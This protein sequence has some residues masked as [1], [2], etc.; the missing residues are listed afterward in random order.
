MHVFLL[1]GLICIVCFLCFVSFKSVFMLMFCDWKYLRCFCVV[2][3][4]IQYIWRVACALGRTKARLS[5]QWV[6]DPA[7]AAYYTQP[8]THFAGLQQCSAGHRR[9]IRRH[10]SATQPPMLHHWLHWV[11]HD[12]WCL[13]EA[14]NLFSSSSNLQLIV[15]SRCPK[16]EKAP[17]KWYRTDSFVANMAHRLF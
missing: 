6:Q 1:C 14:F 12:Q 2:S 7:E 11:E 8:N 9:S 15:C 16:V 3:M 5:A 4:G 10:D 17:F 13:H